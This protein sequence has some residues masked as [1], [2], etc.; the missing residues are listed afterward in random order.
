MED[1]RRGCF[2]GYFGRAYGNA[3]RRFMTHNVTS[4]PSFVALQKVHSIT[5]SAVTSKL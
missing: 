1:D 2:R 5:S 4:P 3:A